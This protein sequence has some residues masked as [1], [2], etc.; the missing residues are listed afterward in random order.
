MAD[1]NNFASSERS[2]GRGGEEMEIDLLHLG[3]VLWKRIWILL[4][5]AVL[6][7]VIAYVGVTLAVKP[8]YQSSA[9]MYVN[10]SNISLGNTKV[11]ITSSELSAAKSLVDVY[12]IILKSR[13][14]LEQVIDEAG[15]P[16]NYT[17]LKK[18][19]S[20]GSVNNTEVF[21]ITATSTDAVEAQ[22][23]V[24]TITRI[25]PER[26]SEIIDGTSVSIVDYAVVEPNKVAPVSSRYAIIGAILGI[27]LSGGIIIVIDL[28]D[29][30]VRGEEY[31]LQK[32]D[33]PLL[34]VIPDLSGKGSDS[35]YY[36]YKKRETAR[37]EEES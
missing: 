3:Q 33:T 5:A 6:F 16:Y 26:I 36:Y 24:S 21:Q 31:L 22:V 8:T 30:T 1:S 9:M 28:L 25:L 18:M 27:L 12:A 37:Q 29:N 7:A 23:I 17:Q 35:S 13:T 32:Y 4:L 11:N 2:S 34:A 15:L 19:V 20:A 10:S 14:T